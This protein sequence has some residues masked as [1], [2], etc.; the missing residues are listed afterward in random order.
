MAKKKAKK[1]AGKKAGKKAKSEAA[2]TSVNTDA[3]LQAA[4]VVTW[5]AEGLLGIFEYQHFDIG[6]VVNAF[7]VTVDQVSASSSTAGQGNAQDGWEY[8]RRQFVRRDFAD[9]PFLRVFGRV[10]EILLNH[11]RFRTITGGDVFKVF[12]VE[13]SEH[14]EEHHRQNSPTT[15]Q[16]PSVSEAH[17]TTG[18]GRRTFNERMERL[19]DE[20]LVRPTVIRASGRKEDYVLTEDGQNMFD[21]WPPLSEIPGLELEGPV[22]PESRSRRRSRRR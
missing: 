14:L 1:K 16:P 18:A 2:A 17:G 4:V 5:G 12:L 15:G 3:E 10:A 6:A 7:P 13:I 9:M 19:Y 21:G 11:R 20:E 22:T 8:A